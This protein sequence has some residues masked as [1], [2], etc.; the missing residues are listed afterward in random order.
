MDKIE[1]L[2]EE[3]R[4]DN[5]KTRE[6]A[7]IT[8]HR[9]MNKKAVPVL[10]K[11]LKDMQV[12]GLAAWELGE[13]RDASAVSAL[14]E[15]L[16]D[17]DMRCYAAEALGKI[18]DASAVSKLITLLKGE[19]R[20]VRKVANQA[21]DK[22]F[23]QCKTI[24]DASAVPVLVET[25]KDEGNDIDM[26]CQAVKALGKIVSS[27]AVAALIEALKDEAVQKHV[28]EALEI[29]KI[30]EKCKTIEDFEEI[31]G[32]ID[33]GSTALR[34]GRVDKIMLIK[35]QIKLAKLT[36]KITER[37]NELASKKDLL[38]DDKPKYPKKGGKVY[39]TI[40]AIR[41]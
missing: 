24:G 17:E 8:L 34:K 27:S 32:G 12:K 10:I 16:K 5:P 1:E 38:L 9:I 31:E 37:K 21:L 23:L 35:A 29:E 6:A 19:D 14:I 33:K 20:F 4:S 39:R 7:G 40:K 11:A 13:I 18:G 15:A 41:R 2:L 25:L 28:D 26:R 36:R 30:V 22:I 3:L